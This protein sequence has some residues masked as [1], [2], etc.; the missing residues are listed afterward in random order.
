MRL[1]DTLL[2]QI[3][4]GLK[5][6]TGF[7][8][9]LFSQAVRDESF[10]QVLQFATNDKRP[11]VL[12]IE[13]KATVDRR[14]QILSFKNRHGSEGVLGT[15]RMSAELG[16]YCRENNV[17]FADA[18]G[19]CF[20]KTDDL[21][22]FILGQKAS[23]QNLLSSEPTVTPATLRV[24]L[25]VLTQPHFL[26]ASVREIG[27]AAR[28]SHGA[29][30]KA[31]ESLRQLGFY[32]E[33]NSARRMLSIPERWLDVWTEGYIARIRPKLLKRRM[34]A[35]SMDAARDL[36]SPAMG[37]VELGGEAAASKLGYS[38]VPGELTLYVN[39][40]E[41]GVLPDLVRWLKLRADP[42][43]SIELVDMFWNS[44]ALRSFPTVPEPLIYADLIWSSNSRNLEIA[45]ELRKAICE[46]VQSQS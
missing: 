15:R 3:V 28:I 1:E 5:R 11:F 2:D 36:V 25:A 23:P 33:T 17:M 38:L 13:V 44:P 24:M 43:G 8:V 21:L 37:E 45:Q 12:P 40:Q 30:G 26:N 16:Q 18:A 39:M 10:D 35:A 6:A 32:V 19:N 14:D 22:V 34:R 9:E 42:A 46:R 31:L 7:N 27:E 20:L 4:D 41:P 29:A